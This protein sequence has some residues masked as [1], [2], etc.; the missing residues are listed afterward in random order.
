MLWSNDRNFN[1]EDFKNQRYYLVAE[2]NDLITKA[3]YDL[4]ARELKIMDYIISKIKPEDEDFNIIQTS[5]YEISNV[6]NLKKSGRTYSQLA[7]S[8][9]SM[10]KKDIYIYDEKERSVVM[11]GWLE[12]AK[13]W[14]NG[15]LELKI[16]K[17][18]APYLLQLKGDGHYT[19][20]FL[21]DTVQL[22][23][24]YSILLYKLMR[25]ADK[26]YGSS[27]AI[28]QGSVEDFKLWLGSP[29]SYTYSRLKENIIC[30]AIEEINLK[31]KD[32]DIELFQARRGRRIT[33]IELH[34][35][36]IRNKKY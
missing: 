29:K 24:K 4:T 30:P 13:M 20:Y 8:L 21:D 11:T 25:E 6:L 26:D 17:E 34:N 2:H 3:R 27:I 36:F 7:N 23:S 19:Q 33:Q 18:F 28:I 22:K 12:T 14:E 1:E 5:M 32:M 16:N 9:N 15:K 31:I 35:N 10:R